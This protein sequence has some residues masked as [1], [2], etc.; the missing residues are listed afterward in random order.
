METEKLSRT[1]L[2]MLTEALT[3]WIIEISHNPKQN[4]SIEERRRYK[5]L[6]VKVVRMMK[7]ENEEIKHK[8]SMP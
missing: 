2:R 8:I 3:F 7:T 6:F 5:E 1:E 4:K